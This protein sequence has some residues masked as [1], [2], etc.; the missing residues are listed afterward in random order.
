MI[1]GF[2]IRDQLRNGTILWILHDLVPLPSESENLQAGSDPDTTF[3]IPRLPPIEP[4]GKP[5]IRFRTCSVHRG[6]L[7][8]PKIFPKS[9]KGS[10]PIWAFIDRVGS[11]RAGSAYDGD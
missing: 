2:Q 6:Y 9:L 11:I 7:S 5:F 10:R 8:N 3:L 1:A 4:L